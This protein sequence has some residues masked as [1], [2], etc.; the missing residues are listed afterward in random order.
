MYKIVLVGDGIVADPGLTT[1]DY[2]GRLFSRGKL[3]RSPT[4]CP[5]SPSITEPTRRL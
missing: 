2:N 5:F 3:Q 4:S 1:G